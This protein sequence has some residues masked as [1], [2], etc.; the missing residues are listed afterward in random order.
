[1]G[2]SLIEL[3]HLLAPAVAA[4][5]CELWGIEYLSQGRHSVLR[6]YIDHAEGI[7]IDTCAQ[8]S[9]QVSAVLDVEDPVSGEYTLEVSS[10]GVDRQLFKLSHYQAYAG[11]KIQVR[12]R[13]PFAGRRKIM[14]VLIG[15]EETQVIVRMDE[16]E[17][18][19]P[20][21]SIDKAH[22]VA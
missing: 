3:E 9:G 5:G 22:L 7:S 1:M 17:F 15:T 8:V 20:I 16:D 12:L 13:T 19:L 21:E 14:G 4:C 2:A 18:V 6:V 11:H 10:P